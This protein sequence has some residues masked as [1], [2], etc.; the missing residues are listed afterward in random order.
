M[1]DDEQFAFVQDLLAE[2]KR[3]NRNIEAWRKDKL[4][5]TESERACAD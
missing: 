4:G 1:T 2:I 3:L 5:L